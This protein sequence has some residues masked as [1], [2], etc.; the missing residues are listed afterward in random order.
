[1]ILSMI[2]AVS[3]A[4]PV[5]ITSGTDV[6][7]TVA[8]PVTYTWT[9]EANGTLTVTMG[10][11][12]PGWQFSIFDAEGNEISVTYSPMNYIVRMNANGSDSLKALLKALYNYHLAAKALRTAS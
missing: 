6:P 9:A 1:M 12:S 7:A 11:A 2:P 3:A 4:E 10:A 5:V 8:E